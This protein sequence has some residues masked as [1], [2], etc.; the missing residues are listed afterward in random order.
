MNWSDGMDGY[1]SHAWLKLAENGEDLYIDVTWDSG[2]IKNREFVNSP[3][4]AYYL[5]PKIC[6]AVDHSEEGEP[7]K[8]LSEQKA[9]VSANLSAFNARCPLLKEKILSK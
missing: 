7:E 8:S 6:I 3:S 9:Y 5:I 1:A 2:Y 4:A